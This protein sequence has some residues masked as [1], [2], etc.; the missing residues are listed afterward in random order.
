MKF[1]KV[2][3]KDYRGRQTH[4]SNHG[5]KFTKTPGLKDRNGVELPMCRECKGEPATTLECYDCERTLSIERFS[6]S[7][8]K[9]K[10]GRVSNRLISIASPL[11]F[12]AVYR[13]LA[14]ASRQRTRH[15]RRNS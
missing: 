6:K 15:G 10:D 9:N 1:S 2:S 13:L 4:R 3:I 8:R 7:Q 5:G 12:A 11:T 14:G